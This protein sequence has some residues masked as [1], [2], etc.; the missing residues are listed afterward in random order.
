MNGR[1]IFSG[2]TTSV[3]VLGQRELGEGNR[4]SNRLLGLSSFATVFRRSG[5]DFQ[6]ME[7]NSNLRALKGQLFIFQGG[8]DEQGLSSQSFSQH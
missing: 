1:K 2:E 6:T 4:S 7:P 3:G 5:L 8:R